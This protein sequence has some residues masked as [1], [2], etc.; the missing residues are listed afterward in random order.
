MDG[1]LLHHAIDR[2]GELLQAGALLGLDDVLR[3]ARRLLLGL[4]KLVEQAALVLGDGLAARLL[5]GRDG[6]LGF[7]CSR[8]SWTRTSCCCPTRSCSSW[9]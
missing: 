6:R 5:Q 9:R 7:R 4:G 3:Q 8:L 1:E 2:R